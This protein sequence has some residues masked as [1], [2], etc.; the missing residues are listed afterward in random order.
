MRE[1]REGRPQMSIKLAESPRIRGLVRT[2]GGS[3][4]LHSAIRPQSRVRRWLRPGISHRATPLDPAA[5]APNGG[6]GLYGGP[7]KT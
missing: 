3:S 5:Q 1:Q 2:C 6:E 4:P 7:E